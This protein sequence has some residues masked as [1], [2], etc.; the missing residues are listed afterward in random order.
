MA[1]HY[2]PDVKTDFLLVKISLLVCRS[3]TRISKRD[4]AAVETQ[5]VYVTENRIK[6]FKPS[7]LFGLSNVEVILWVQKC[8]LFCQSSDHRKCQRR[9]LGAEIYI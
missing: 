9:G 6:V 8:P 5:F 1:I 7:R 3:P 4:F 2:L